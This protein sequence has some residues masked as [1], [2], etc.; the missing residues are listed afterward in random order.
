MRF[1]KAYLGKRSRTLISLAILMV[2]LLI[3]TTG[4]SKPPAKDIDL[5]ANLIGSSLGVV[6]GLVVG[7]SVYS[8]LFS[9]KGDW[10]L[11]YTRW[12][13]I[14]LSA[15]ALTLLYSVMI[16]I[17]TIL[18]NPWL[19]TKAFLITAIWAT[20]SRTVALIM[21]RLT[22]G[23]EE[24][25]RLGLMLMAVIV[26]AQQTLSLLGSGQFPLIWQIVML[27]TSTAVEIL[28]LWGGEAKWLRLKD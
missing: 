1:L 17:A 2:V 3:A 4:G 26:F 21:A 11:T 12:Y 13:D 23:I 27:L 8:T 5:L 10:W 20:S 15:N 18:K 25:L 16:F 24:Y 28:I 19:P 22:W 9:D 7:W 6:L 14:W